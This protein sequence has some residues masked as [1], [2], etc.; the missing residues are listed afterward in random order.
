MLSFRLFILFL[1]PTAALLGH[2]VVRSDFES[3]SIGRIEEIAPDHLRCSVKGQV[4]QDG[5]NRQASWYYFEIDGATRR[6]IT[7]DLTDLPGEYNYRPGNLAINRKTRPFI[8]YNRKTWTPLPASAVTWADRGPVLS[9]HFVPERSRLWIAHVPPYT[10]RD[11]SK[12]LHE[13]SGDSGAKTTEI[14]KSVRGRPLYQ[15]TVTNPAVPEK[16]KKVIW[17]VARQHA[18]ESGTSW[19]VDG[20]LES[21]AGP[22]ASNTRLLDSVIFKFFPMGDPDG[23]V[24]GGV[25]FNVNGYDLNRNWDAVDT[26]LMPEIAAPRRTILAWVD[27]GHRIDLL[28]NLHNDNTDYLQG[29]LAAAG[30]AYARAIKQIASLLTQNTAFDGKEP[31][32]LPAGSPEHGRMDTFQY[33]FHARK[34]AVALLELNVQTNARLGRPLN[35]QDYRRFGAQLM[36]ALAAAVS[37]LPQ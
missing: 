37:G 8:S 4:D 35:S 36:G 32:D 21:L 11:L 23:L 17:L 10:T 15:V 24:G 13:V 34:I 25:R 27:G 26:R 9:I 16:S 22:N 7:I 3:G 33:L 28:M 2:V 5:R 30:P 1:L 19:V 18:W 31:R 12:L 14:G 6:E 20:A 29:P